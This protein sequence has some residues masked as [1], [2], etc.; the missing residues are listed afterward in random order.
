MATDLHLTSTASASSTICSDGGM[1]PQRWRREAGSGGQA[2]RGTLA[3]GG[4]VQLAI[5]RLQA[6]LPYVHAQTG[7]S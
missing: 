4:Q 3:D 5:P 1:H 7:W 2:E 6:T